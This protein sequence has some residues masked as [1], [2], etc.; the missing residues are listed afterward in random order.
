VS[1]IPHKLRRGVCWRAMR[2]RWFWPR[3]LTVYSACKLRNEAGGRAHCCSIAK[4]QR[5]GLRFSFAAKRHVAPRTHLPLPDHDQVRRDAVVLHLAVVLQPRRALRGV[6]VSDVAEQRSRGQLRLPVM[7]VAL[8][9][10][11]AQ[12]LR[13]PKQ[14]SRHLRAEAGSG[15]ENPLSTVWQSQRLSHLDVKLVLCEQMPKSDCQAS[16][17]LCAS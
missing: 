3:L 1:A 12:I 2:L 5:L 10:Q 6:G 17:S 14:N 15:A 16:A 13:G 9:E 11:V 8:R 4:S 7:V